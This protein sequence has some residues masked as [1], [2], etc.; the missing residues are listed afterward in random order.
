[1][2]LTTLVVLSEKLVT[3]VIS[4]SLSWEPIHVAFIVA[5]EYANADS[6]PSPNDVI[7]TMESDYQSSATS[8]DTISSDVISSENFDNLAKTPNQS[9]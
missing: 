6:S 9:L 7:V 4:S 2:I 8:P 3:L 1:M 5:I